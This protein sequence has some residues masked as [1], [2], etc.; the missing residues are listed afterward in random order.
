MDDLNLEKLKQDVAKYS[1]LLYRRGLVGAAGGNVSTR[2]DNRILVTAGNKSL[3]S[4]SSNEVL[5]VDLLQQAG[6]AP[7]SLV[8]LIDLAGPLLLHHLTDHL[9]I[10][11]LLIVPGRIQMNDTGIQGGTN[12]MGIVGIHHAHTDDGQFESCFSQGAIDDLTG[13]SW[14]L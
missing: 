2:S 14:L 3:R 6:V 1:N 10:T 4:I 13:F 5:V 8:A 12:Q 9:F 7:N 11:P